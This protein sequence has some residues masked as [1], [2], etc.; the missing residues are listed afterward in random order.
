VA[1][2]LSASIFCK[3]GLGLPR[4]PETLMAI[5]EDGYGFP[6]GHATAAAGLG[7]ALVGVSRWERRWP[8]A[9]AATYVAVIAATRVLL[10][11]HYLPDVLVGVALGV[12]FA[13]AGLR[14]D[15]LRPRLTFAGTTGVVAL[16]L[17]VW[18]L[19]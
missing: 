13:G 8:L 14:A 10:G 16:A 9:L 5:P 1:L 19:L 7:T 4:P 17:S 12:L 18:A 3:Y 15:R 2:V 6:S 11:V